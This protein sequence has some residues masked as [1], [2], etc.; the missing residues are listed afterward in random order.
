MIRRAAILWSAVPLLLWAAAAS[1]VTA[2]AEAD[3]YEAVIKVA[4]QALPAV[5]EIEAHSPQGAPAT[6]VLGEARRGT[7]TLIDPTGLILTSNHVVMGSDRIMVTLTD[8]RK[9]PAALTRSD[10]HRDLAFLRVKGEGLPVLPLG[11]SVGMRLGQGVVIVGSGMGTDRE[12]TLGTLNATGPF[13]GYWEFMLD[14]ILQTDAF[15]RLGYSGGPLLNLQGEVVGVIS[16][17]R[18]TTPGF[19]GLVVPVEE[20]YALQR[21]MRAPAKAGAR[22][23]LG[24]VVQVGE[25]GLTL[26]RLTPGGPASQTG[27]KLKDLITHVNGRRVRRM[28]E[29]FRAIWRNAAG[30][31]VRLTV[32]RK[33]DVVTILVK[34]ADRDRFFA[35]PKP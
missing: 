31:E 24:T 22:A 19:A 20:V 34:S 8:G 12:V 5:V 11:R 25:G 4:K 2:A 16:F 33:G 10:A 9:L 13:V 30:D 6:Q 1:S 35:A 14:R 7:G 29:Y 27:L 21:E 23:W 17:I 26:E 3:P 18:R 28:S 15:V 32:I